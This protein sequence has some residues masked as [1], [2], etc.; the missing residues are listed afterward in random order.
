MLNN[1]QVGTMS[2]QK[3]KKRIALIASIIS[4]IV[5]TATVLTYFFFFRTTPQA[6]TT[7]TDKATQNQP[8]S[9][10]NE[11]LRTEATSL[12]Q[13][14]GQAASQQKLDEAL[15]A[16]TDNTD[17]S[18]IYTLKIAVASA[19]AEPSYQTILDY[20]YQAEKLNPTYETAL[21]VAEIEKQMANKPNAITYYKLYLERS[22]TADGT[23]LDPAGR[24]FYEKTLKALES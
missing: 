8:V 18:Y 20:A 1:K 23:L 10:K 19:A 6:A 11:A 24:S 2:Q 4:L 15:T 22:I 3:S 16:T 9:K 13:S 7:K 14:K 17:K 5:I 12:L 21:N